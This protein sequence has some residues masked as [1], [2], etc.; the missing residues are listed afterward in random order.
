M[1]DL[2]NNLR[3]EMN[4][5]PNEIRC[6]SGNC[7]DNCN[8]M[9]QHTVDI[10]ESKILPEDGYRIIITCP[11]VNCPEDSITEPIIGV[12][13]RDIMEALQRGL[14]IPIV[15]YS[16]LVEKQIDR[17]AE[18]YKQR[19]R[20]KY[21]LGTLKPVDLFHVQCF[22]GVWEKSPKILHYSFDT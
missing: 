16:S 17:W 11:K 1:N 4:H 12:N 13:G 10:L 14:Q 18:K 20:N 5:P 22:T 19:L 8:F 3:W 15:G 21:S 9:C 2:M 7:V 6:V